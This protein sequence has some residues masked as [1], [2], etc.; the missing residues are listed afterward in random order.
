MAEIAP[1]RPLHVAA[2]LLAGCVVGPHYSRPS[3]P[4]PGAYK[5]T[6]DHWKQA[7]PADQVLRGK[8]WEIY[9]NPELNSLEEKINVSNQTIKA[10][11]AQFFQAR[12]LVRLARAGYYPTV[13]AGASATRNR[14]SRAPSPGLRHHRLHRLAPP[15]RCLV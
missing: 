11:E 8:W 4:V 13:T 7:E 14:L 15:G 9:Q 5:E 10:A 6:P 2:W 1:G 12:A 3:A